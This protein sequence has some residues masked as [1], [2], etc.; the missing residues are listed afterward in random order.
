MA[1]QEAHVYKYADRSQLFYQCQISIAIKEPN[2]ECARPQCSEPQGFGAVKTSGAAA[3]PAAAAQLRLLKK[4]SAEAENIVDVRTDIS[5]LEISENVYLLVF[6][7]FY[8][9]SLRFLEETINNY[10][11][12]LDICITTLF[13]Q[14]YILPFILFKMDFRT[15][16]YQLIYAIMH[17]CISVDNRWYLLQYR[18]EFVC[19]HSAS[20]CL[21]VWALHSLLPLS[22]L[23]PLNFV[24]CKKHEIKE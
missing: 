1:G 8:D 24:Q 3:K 18:T 4:R 9:F 17:V 16:L 7:S 6:S 11:E 10:A 19:H 15:K 20:Q 14:L 23:Y 12:A 22:S 21:W 13:F 5:A 2:S